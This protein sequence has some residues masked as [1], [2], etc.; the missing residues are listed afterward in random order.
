[1]LTREDLIELSQRTCRSHGIDPEREDIRGA[2]NN[3]LTVVLGEMEWQ[4]EE[5]VQLQ[6]FAEKILGLQEG[7]IR[8]RE[9][10]AVVA[11]LRT[12]IET[13]TELAAFYCKRYQLLE[14]K[15]PDIEAT[16]DLLAVKAL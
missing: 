2:M 13:C 4:A 11:S 12:Y 1:M 6:R 16:A 8:S 10:C 9:E 7:L 5:L 3:V 15:E 14:W